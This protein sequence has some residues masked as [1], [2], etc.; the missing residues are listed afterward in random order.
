MDA[1][2]DFYMP[3]ALF[4]QKGNI[5][6]VVPLLDKWPE[7]QPRL[8][9]WKPD[10]M[11]HSAWQ[12]D[13]FFKLTENR[14]GDWHE[15]QYSLQAVIDFVFPPPETA[16][17]PSFQIQEDYLKD[18]RSRHRRVVLWILE[19]AWPSMKQH[20]FALKES[21]CSGG[22]TCSDLKKIRRAERTTG[23]TGSSR[24]F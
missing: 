23:G 9:F 21:G 16:P 11:F 6:A 15:V 24:N 10:S 18:L 22:S 17:Q 14:Q 5:V 20:F 12:P 8:F 2:T 4:R 3:N 13:A 7:E 1:P 19:E